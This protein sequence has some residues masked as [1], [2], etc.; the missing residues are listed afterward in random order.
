VGQTAA[1]HLLDCGLKHFAFCGWGP[2]QPTAQ[3]WE[4]T[5]ME[6]ASDTVARRGYALSVYEWP[7]RASERAWNASQVH[8]AA[9][10]QTLPKPVGVLAANDERALEVLDA[11]QGA[12]L[13][14]PDEIAIIGV[15]NDEVLC[16]AAHPSLSSVALNLERIG[17]EGATLLDRLMRG[18]RYPKRPIL[19]PPLRVVSRS[20]TDVVATADEI[21]RTAVRFI[22]HNLHRPLGVAEVLEAVNVS[23]KTL[24]VRFAAALGRSPY[25]EI[26]RRRIERIKELLTRTDGKM[27]RVAQQ[28]GFKHV[29]NLYGVFRREVGET[30]AQYRARHTLR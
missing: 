26:L 22:Q 1:E 19:I 20:S 15:D 4:R 2:A 16:E 28:C 21:V 25:E 14:V 27:K 18:G 23:R 13:C 3:I 7:R 11:A 12:G 6:S 30:P 24:E 29:E 10:L 5:R 17:Y 9:W 8:L